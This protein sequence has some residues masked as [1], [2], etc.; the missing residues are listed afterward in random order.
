[1]HRLRFYKRLVKK[2]STTGR[3]IVKVPK[4]SLRK[5]CIRVL[6]LLQTRFCNM[7]VVFYT[8]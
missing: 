4:M 8:K 3:K 5:H 7:C 1:M 2:R 6:R